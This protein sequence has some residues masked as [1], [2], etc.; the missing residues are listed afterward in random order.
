[1]PMVDLEATP[2]NVEISQD[3]PGLV[4]GQVYALSFE[5]GRSGNDGELEV[6]WNGALVGS[7]VPGSGLMQTVGLDLV[8]G[9]GTNTLS[10][11]EVGSNAGNN[12]GTYLANIS[13]TPPNYAVVD[14]DGLVGPS[15][16][17]SSGPG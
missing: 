4:E 1:A 5:M 11:K 15:A 12:T 13:L 2:G 14:E 17:V 3:I 6:Y 7:Y 9:P 10:F 16:G 8:A